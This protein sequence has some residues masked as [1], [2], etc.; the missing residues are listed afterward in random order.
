MK[1]FAPKY[2]N[3][4]ACKASLCQHTCCIGWKICVDE[5][6]IQDFE[7]LG[8]EVADRFS[9]SL[10]TDDGDVVIK[11][12]DDGRCPHLLSSGLCSI[13]SEV[14]AKPLPEICREHP[15]FYNVF[16]KHVEVGL[17]AVCEAATELIIDGCDYNSLFDIGEVETDCGVNKY[18]LSKRGDI[19]SLL[20]GKEDN[21]RKL[22]KVLLEIGAEEVL[23]SFSYDVFCE[24]EYLDDA[25]KSLIT[26]GVN[27]PI[28]IT[29][30]GVNILS[31]FIYRH[32]SYAYDRNDFASRVIFSIISMK[33]VLGMARAGISLTEALRI[34]SLEIEYSADN[35]EAILFEIDC[36]LL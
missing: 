2:Y 26:S 20:S 29:D 13:I 33:C 25:D 15:R 27:E 12:C 1:L 23:D 22:K 30:E 19:F 18:G 4:F 16:E 32:A 28:E 34:Y 5:R 17:G 11:L 10:I 31:Y 36:G 35:T 3:K 7:K 24:L 14:G 9:R 21:N 8:G 6:C